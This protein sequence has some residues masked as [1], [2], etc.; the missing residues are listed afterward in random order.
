MNNPQMMTIR[1]VAERCATE[2]IGVGEHFI[3]SAV[4]RD[5]LPHVRAGS[6]VLIDWDTF[7]DYLRCPASYPA[8][9]PEGIHR[10][11]GR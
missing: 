5:S 8:P 4:K 6:R 3:R 9:L 11:G 7:C 1:A 2:G 10:I